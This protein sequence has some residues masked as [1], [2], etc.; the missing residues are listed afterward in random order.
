MNKKVSLLAI[1][2]I[3]ILIC[4]PVFSEE[5]LT[6][7]NIVNMVKAGLGDELILTKIGTSKNQFDVSTD[8]ILKL[9]NEG[10]NEKIIQAMIEAATK[11]SSDAVAP[12]V[13]S[14]PKGSDVGNGQCVIEVPDKSA[15]IGMVIRA[16][17]TLHVLTY[18]TAHIDSRTGGLIA[19]TFS[20]GIA[21]VRSKTTLRIDRAR[22][23]VRITD[24]QPEFLNLLYSVG[25]SAENFYVVR[26]SVEG[27]ARYVQVGSTEKNLAG[28]RSSSWVMPDGV[29]VEMKSQTISSKCSWQ[30][31][32]YSH[33]KIWPLR[34]LEP[35]E[36]AFVSGKPDGKGIVMFDLGV[37]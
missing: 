23:S 24:R 28:S 26:L 22:A 29:R 20:H 7:E 27:D 32:E 17:G 19:Y 37:D 31:K 16:G 5:I 15:G 8:A 6:N 1:M 10:A 2:M 11:K 12:Q 25:G 36:Y 30:G 34:P 4:G 33:H 3:L 35:G 18:K 13:S 14:T 9:K 21:P